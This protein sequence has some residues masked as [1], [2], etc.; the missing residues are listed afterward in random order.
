VLA[1]VFTSAPGALRT[2]MPGE[3]EVSASGC[4]ARRCA[5]YPGA[6]GWFGAY[7]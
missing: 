6:Y 4:G 1:T 7:W 5:G 3:G 2:Q